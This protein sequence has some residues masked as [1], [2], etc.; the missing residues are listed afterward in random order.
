[1]HDP[2]LTPWTEPAGR[3][4]ASRLRRARWRRVGARTGR[5]LRRRILVVGALGLALGLGSVHTGR[6]LMTSPDAAKL[7]SFMTEV[8]RDWFSRDYDFRTLNRLY[9]QRASAAATVRPFGR[10]L[11]DAMESLR[12]SVVVETFFPTFAW[13]PGSANHYEVFTQGPLHSY[14]L[15]NKELA[16]G[17]FA[18]QR[19][20]ITDP[21]RNGWWTAKPLE[22]KQIREAFSDVV[23]VDAS[24]EMFAFIQDEMAQLYADLRP[25]AT[26]ADPAAAIALADA[27]LLKT[28]RMLERQA[29]LLS[30]KLRFGSDLDALTVD[31]QNIV[32]AKLDA[33]V[34]TADPALWREKQMLDFAAGIIGVPQA[35]NAYVNLCVRPFMAIRT[36]LLYGG[37]LL[38]VGFSMAIAYRALEP[39]PRREPA[40]L[41]AR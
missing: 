25:E 22:E 35:T 20:A 36:T 30:A 28:N 2:S 1:M 27:D 32:L 41:W 19:Q 12:S 21:L 8:D 33:H 26:E 40:R 3:S 15:R 39:V 10:P 16:G 24:P 6:S 14:L 5:W 37:L 13:D 11:V 29:Q 17:Y 9:A 38:I 18:Q 23:A 7:R 31:Q 34:Q 4:A